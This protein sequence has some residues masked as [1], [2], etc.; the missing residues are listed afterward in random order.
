MKCDRHF[1]LARFYSEGRLAFLRYVTRPGCAFPITPTS[2]RVHQP[3][4]AL[5]Q[6]RTAALTRRSS[7]PPTPHPSSGSTSRPA[8]HPHMRRSHAVTLIAF[9]VVVAGCSGNTPMTVSHAKVTTSPSS[10]TTIATFPNDPQCDN[11]DEVRRGD[12][13]VSQLLAVQTQLSEALTSESRYLSA[14]SVRSSESDWTTYRNAECRLVA[15]TYRGGTIYPWIVGACEW[16][17]TKQRLT[18]VQQE[19][20]LL[21]QLVPKRSSAMGPG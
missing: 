11:G 8:Y 13:V 17:L 12:C 19:V 10:T 9:A 3:S 21:D 20:R 4:V 14:T 7:Q 16:Q 1:V 2:Y 5:S 18:D 15:S 6:K